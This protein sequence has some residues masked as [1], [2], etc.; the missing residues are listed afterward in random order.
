MFCD[1][2]PLSFNSLRSKD[3]TVASLLL[4]RGQWKN[5]C[6][7][8][9]PK[10]A[11]RGSQMWTNGGGHQN[12]QLN[13]S[14]WKTLMASLILFLSI[15]ERRLIPLITRYCWPN[16]LV[17]N[18]SPSTLNW[19][20]HICKIR[21]CQDTEHKIGTE[22]QSRG[23]AGVSVRPTAIQSINRWSAKSFERHLENVCQWC[24]SLCPCKR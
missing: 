22:Q 2:S 10:I 13:A 23:T 19:I 20:I 4:E 11:K 8:I 21:G 3:K 6:R 5:Q 24:R 9:Y 7:I 15:S 1:K 16:R 17:Y 14:F 12:Y 18:F